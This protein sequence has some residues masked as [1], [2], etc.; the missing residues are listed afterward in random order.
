MRAGSTELLSEPIISFNYNADKKVLHSRKRFNC[1]QSFSQF[2]N[3]CNKSKDG[4]WR[5]SMT[6]YCVK[7]FGKALDIEMKLFPISLKLSKYNQATKH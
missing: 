2:P 3:L 7:H 6:S 5:L 4:K 1:L